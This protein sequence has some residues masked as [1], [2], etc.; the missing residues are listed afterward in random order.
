MSQSNA[1][2]K[3]DQNNLGAAIYAQQKYTVCLQIK[4]TIIIDATKTVI[5]QN[6]VFTMSRI[7][8]DSLFIF[9]SI[10]KK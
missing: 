3:I 7:D 9:V 10:L 1:V 2:R 4:T 8:S 6:G 5:E